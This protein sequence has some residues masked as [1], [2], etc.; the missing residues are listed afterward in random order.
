MKL[1]AGQTSLGRL[2]EDSSVKRDLDTI[3]GER[4]ELSVFLA[5]RMEVPLMSRGW[6]S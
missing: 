4:E 5:S 1:S 2:T 3:G 6:K